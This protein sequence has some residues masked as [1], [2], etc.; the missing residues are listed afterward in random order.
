VILTEL[1]TPTTIVECGFLSNSEE[2][3]RLGSEDYQAQLA[4]AIKK[5]IDNYFK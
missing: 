5:G 2:E 3:R 4:A 1:K